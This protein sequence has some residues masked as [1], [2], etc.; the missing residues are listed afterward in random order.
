MAL[1]GS[2]TPWA[3]HENPHRPEGFI[4]HARPDAPPGPPVKDPAAPRTRAWDR[5]LRFAPLALIVA[6]AVL[7]YAS[8]LVHHLSLA[9]LGARRAPLEAFAAARPIVSALIYLAIFT[10]GVALSLPIALIL[11]LTG[12]FLFGTLEGGLL[13]ATACTTGGVAIFLI[14]RTAAGDALK[15]LAGPRIQKLQAGAQRDAMTVI[16]TLRLL[17]MMPFWL[18]NIGAAVIGMPARTFLVGTAIGVA[19]SSFI[20]AALGSGLAGLF[21]P[22]AHLRLATLERPQVFVPVAA[23]LILSVAP[24]AWRRLHPRPEAAE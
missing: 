10:A 4:R 11:T 9:E 7:A 1:S 14:S 19:P 2:P 15:R 12:G 17:P 5:T 3:P 24:L 23:L 8:G 20:Y 16:L 13:A 22:G 6:L 18:I 21:E